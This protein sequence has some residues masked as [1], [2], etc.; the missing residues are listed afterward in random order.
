MK[1]KKCVKNKISFLTHPKLTTIEGNFHG[2]IFTQFS[3]LPASRPQWEI[4]V[5]KYITSSHI[6][7]SG[8]GIINSQISV[9]I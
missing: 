9:L 5:R 6:D 2:L 7:F 8:L 3:Q 1:R 4:I